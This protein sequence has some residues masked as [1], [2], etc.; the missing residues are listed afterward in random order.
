MKTEAFVQFTI[1]CGIG[2]YLQRDGNVYKKFKL[3]LDT[4]MKK[5]EN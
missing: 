2:I 3:R 1:A 4:L 5:S